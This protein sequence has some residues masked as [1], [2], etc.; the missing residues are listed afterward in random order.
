[1]V[2]LTI[3]LTLTLHLTF[4]GIFLIL[5]K[6]VLIRAFDH[7]LTC[8]SIALG[9]GDNGGGEYYL[10]PAGRDQL[11]TSIVHGFKKTVF[12]DVIQKLL[13]TNRNIIYQ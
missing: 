12:T 4:E 7:R 13:Q 1:M 8:L 9:S 2:P 5:I 10:P 3:Y 11:E 6:I